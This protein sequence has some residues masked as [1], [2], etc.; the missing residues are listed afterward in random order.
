MWFGSQVYVLDYIVSVAIIRFIR[1]WALTKKDNSNAF[2]VISN[3]L[4]IIQNDM[5]GLD[6]E[7][8]TL[9]PT[10]SGCT[11]SLTS[12]HKPN[13]PIHATSSVKVFRQ[14]FKA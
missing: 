10:E 3:P 8:L 4:D 2:T 14:I 9:L 13:A 5:K 12:D 11:R 6:Y 1:Y 7:C